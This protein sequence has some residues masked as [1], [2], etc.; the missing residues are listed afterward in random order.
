M[1]R[2]SALAI[3]A[4]LAAPLAPLSAQDSSRGVPG[5]VREVLPTAN[6]L[7]AAV[8]RE[9][10]EAV[11]AHLHERVSATLPEGSYAGREDVAGRWLPA[12]PGGASGW[13]MT[14]DGFAREGET[15]RETGTYARRVESGLCEWE[16]PEPKTERQARDRAFCTPARRTPAWFVERG[17]YR[18]TWARSP[19]G[20]WK[21][22]RVEL[23]VRP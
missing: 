15:I 6:A 21:V 11:A 3:A 14:P 2:L 9:D 16:M 12:A 8:L 22:R 18:V 19:D 23:E 1:L 17:V 20:A 4:A 13:E 5:A 10:R 7:Y